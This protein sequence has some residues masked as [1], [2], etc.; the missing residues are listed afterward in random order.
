MKGTARGSTPNK[1]TMATGTLPISRSVK[2]L[3]SLKPQQK[4]T[5]EFL[6]AAISSSDILQTHID[7]DKT[8][9]QF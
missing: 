4:A 8:N 2:E 9:P 7:R 1:M 5:N 6:N 3:P